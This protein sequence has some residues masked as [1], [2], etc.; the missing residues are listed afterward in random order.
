MAS[1]VGRGKAWLYQDPA[2]G[3]CAYAVS[4]LVTQVQAQSPFWATSGREDGKSKKKPE[5][6]T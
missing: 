5:P 3:T 2:A 6:R 4:L 1:V